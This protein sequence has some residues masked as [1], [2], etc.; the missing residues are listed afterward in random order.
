[1]KRITSTILVAA[2]TGLLFTST[3]VAAADTTPTTTREDRMNEALDRYHDSR[4]ANPGPAAR[5]EESIKRGAHKT[6]QAVKRGAKKAG[7]AVGT[8]LDKTGQALHRAG[9]KIKGKTE[10]EPQPKP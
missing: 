2:A 5:A 6:G 8:G 10:T 3:L 9:D 4:N 1:M 7:H